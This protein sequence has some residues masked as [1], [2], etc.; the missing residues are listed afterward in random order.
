MYGLATPKSDV[1]FM[2]V[3]LPTPEDVLGLKAVDIVDASTKSS[4]A[5]RRNTADDVDDARYTLQSYLQLLLA[6]NPNILETLF[7]PTDVIVVCDP[8]MMPLLEHPERVVCKHLYKSFGGYA[9]SQEHKLT[10]KKARFTELVN[11]TAMLEEEFA[12]EVLDPKAQMNKML[13][14]RLNNTLKHY[15]GAKQHDESFHEGLPMKVIYEKMK[16]ERDTYGWRVKTDTFETLGYDT[17]FASHLVRLYFEAE[18]LLKTGRISFPFMG[19]TR[20]TIMK[21]KLGGMKLDEL[22]KLAE[23][24]RVRVDTAYATTLLPEEPDREYLNTYL[25]A[26]ML[27]YFQKPKA[28]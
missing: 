8:V 1:D 13:A 25:I 28:Y 18:E 5:G 15:R 26:T 27:E 7:T 12:K 22:M 14:F 2:E 3:F 9:K 10:E 19:E 11:A 16:E 4:G 20:D 6:N 21:V 24:L 17:K 23:S